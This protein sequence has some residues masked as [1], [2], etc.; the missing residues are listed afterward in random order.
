MEHKSHE[1]TNISGC[2]FPINGLFGL[3]ACVLARLSVDQTY[4]P[5]C[6]PA[7]WPNS[8]RQQKVTELKSKL[9]KLQES[10][11]LV[12]LRTTYEHAS[13][14][15][16]VKALQ[17]NTDSVRQLLEVRA[18]GPAT[19]PTSDVLFGFCFAW[20]LMSNPVW[21]NQNVGCDLAQ[22]YKY[23]WSHLGFQ[24]CVCKGLVLHHILFEQDWCCLVHNLLHTG[25][26]SPCTTLRNVLWCA[27]QVEVP[28]KQAKYA[29][30]MAK[31]TEKLQDVQQRN[32]EL[33]GGPASLLCWGNWGMVAVLMT[34]GLHGQRS[35]A[36]MQLPLYFLFVGNIWVCSIQGGVFAFCCCCRHRCRCCQG[37]CSEFLLICYA[38]SHKL[39]P[40]GCTASCMCR[41][42]ANGPIRSPLPAPTCTAY[43]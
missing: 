11:S 21:E 30:V 5:T 39:L 34:T 27:L 26:E 1:L 40:S 28:K 36:L 7:L 41:C 3:P 12:E 6:L 25:T 16:G 43:S 31:A 29:A 33:V 18:A 23:W 38:A 42:T 35:Q 19:A 20:L 9:Q 17:A 15:A 13:I 37:H 10:A 22:L 14:W 4:L 8:A 32:D 24:A 2:S